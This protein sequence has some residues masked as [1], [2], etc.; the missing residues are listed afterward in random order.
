MSNPVIR[1]ERLSKKYEIGLAKPRHD[2]LRD[3]FAESFKGLF[4]RHG[5]SAAGGGHDKTFWALRDVSFNVEAGDV[6]G[7]IGRNGAGKS[8]LLKILSRIT[9][10]TTGHAEIHGRVGSLLEVG[11]GF[12]PELT[13]RENI[14]LNGA[15][16]GM[17]K[18]EIAR[19]FDDIVAFADVEKFIDTPVKRYSSGMYVRLAFGGA[20]HLE[21]EVLI[22]DEVL[23]VGDFAFQKKCLGRMSEVADQ[24]RT[25][26]FVSH[27]LAAV[28]NLCN[29]VIMLDKGQT[30]F[31]G[32]PAEVIDAYLKSLSDRSADSEVALI[33]LTRASSRPANFR[34]L[35]RSLEFLSDE[36]SAVS[37]CVK[38]GSPLKIHVTFNLEVATPHLEVTLIFQNALGQRIL[39]VSSTHQP[40]PPGADRTGEHTMVCDI[41]SLPLVP[42][43]YH[44]MVSLDVDGANVD[45]VEDAARISVVDGDYYGCGKARYLGYTVLPHRWYFAETPVAKESV[46]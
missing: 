32:T 25:V 11:T 37:G 21:P 12:H 13:G 3:Q 9:K 8:T 6:V 22:V 4:R 39:G 41:P 42:G 5:A 1:V 28:E 16:L 34:Q 40:D 29:K 2:T 26:L 27:N 33:D 23:A 30:V 17:K 36:D 46:V 18:Q 43:E 24:G 19:K 44:V 10:P 35:L 7:I 45:R 38:L 15:I 14:F 31:A 20:A